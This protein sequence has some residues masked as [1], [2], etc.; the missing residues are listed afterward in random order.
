MGLLRLSHL[1]K[2]DDSDD[3]LFRK[4]KPGLIEDLTLLAEQHSDWVAETSNVLNSTKND[5]C[6]AEQIAPPPDFATPK[7]S[8]QILFPFTFPRAW[9]FFGFL[10]EFLHAHLLWKAQALYALYAN[11]LA[12][13]DD[14]APG[15][16]ESDTVNDIDSDNEETRSSVDDL[17]KTRDDLYG[18]LSTIM[19]CPDAD[20]TEVKSNDLFEEDGHPSHQVDVWR[21]GLSLR[22]LKHFVMC[23]MLDLRA[24]FPQKFKDGVLHGSKL[25]IVS[26]T[27]STKSSLEKNMQLELDTFMHDYL[28]WHV[29]H[30]DTTSALHLLPSDPSEC[31]AAGIIKCI[32]C[33]SPVDKSSASAIALHLLDHDEVQSNVPFLPW[34]YYLVLVFV[35]SCLVWPCLS[36][37]FEN[38]FRILLLLQILNVCVLGISKYDQGNAKWSEAK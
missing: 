14:G 31:V 6:D 37:Y 12:E 38:H 26:D 17:C 23:K 13:N 1:I 27:D 7:G 18:I 25:A 15:E 32:M 24:I 34:S 29:T 5:D 33:D 16:K 2:A 22:N 9:P 19:E 10:L 3:S 11:E 21:R 28:A 30:E 4:M 8:T 36:N 20:D 35:L